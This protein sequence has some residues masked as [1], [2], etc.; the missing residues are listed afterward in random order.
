MPVRIPD[1]LSF[2]E[3]IEKFANIPKGETVD[4]L[5]LH[6]C[7]WDKAGDKKLPKPDF[8]VRKLV[9]LPT[10]ILSKGND[11]DA[12]GAMHAMRSSARTLEQLQ[13]PATPWLLKYFRDTD[14]TKFTALQRAVIDRSLHP[15]VADALIEILDEIVTA[16][17]RGVELPSTGSPPAAKKSKKVELKVEVD[18]LEE[19]EGEGRE[20]TGPDWGVAVVDAAN[21]YINLTTGERMVSATGQPVPY[22]MLYHGQYEGVLSKERMLTDNI[23]DW[24]ANE[25]LRASGRTDVLLCSVLDFQWN[26][27]GTHNSG[28]QLRIEKHG[29]EKRYVVIPVCFDMHYVLFTVDTGKEPGEIVC[30]DSF[31]HG[32]TALSAKHRTLIRKMGFRGQEF[33]TTLGVSPDQDDGVSCGVFVCELVRRFMFD[34]PMDAPLNGPAMR[35][36]MRDYL[37]QQLRLAQ[38]GNPP[39]HLRPDGKIA[40]GLELPPPT[41]VRELA[42]WRP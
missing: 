40:E 6:L 10:T 8:K 37:G 31:K 4:E 15:S 28:H 5:V 21:F 30:Y 39:T 3:Q 18:L 19:S 11:V 34:R 24:F 1:G 29:S 16:N 12:Y 2:N 26:P 35:R 41:P 13:A 27:D 25:C 22:F 7:V 33:R 14:R 9:V 36:Q 20:T 32:I 23:V 38:S 42:M 17:K